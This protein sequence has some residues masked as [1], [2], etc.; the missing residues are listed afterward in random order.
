MNASNR[1]LQWNEEVARGCISYTLTGCLVL[2][3]TGSNAVIE[4]LWV[5]A[6]RHMIYSAIPIFDP[7]SNVRNLNNTAITPYL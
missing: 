3:L 4:D 6:L 5:Y 7:A 1:P 2:A